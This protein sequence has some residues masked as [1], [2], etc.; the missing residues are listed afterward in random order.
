MI[1]WSDGDGEHDAY[2]LQRTVS[3]LFVVDGWA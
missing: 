1:E 2:S 3:Q